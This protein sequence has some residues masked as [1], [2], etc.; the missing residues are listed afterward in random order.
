MTKDKDYVLVM[1][2]FLIR[3]DGSTETGTIS[4]WKTMEEL[5]DYFKCIR[6]GEDDRPF[7]CRWD[8]IVV[9]KVPYGMYGVNE[10]VGWWKGI[11]R[12]GKYNG[13]YNTYDIIK[14]DESPLD[15]ADECFNFTISG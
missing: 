4:L 9:E 10:I 2:S 8:Y 13:K 14:L 3:K 1:K 5:E 6:D 15:Y 7:E 12:K 11:K